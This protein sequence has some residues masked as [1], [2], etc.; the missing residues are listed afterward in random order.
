MTGAFNVG[1]GTTTGVG[2]GTGT[3]VWCG[4]IDGRFL[5]RRRGTAAATAA[6]A[7]LRQE[8][9]LDD[10]V[11]E[12]RRD[13]RAGREVGQHEKQKARVENDGH[14][15][16]AAQLP[17]ARR[18]VRRLSPQPQAG[19][20]TC[21]RSSSQDRRGWEGVRRIHK[22]GHHGD[23]Q[24]HDGAITHSILT[25]HSTRFVPETAVQQLRHD[26][27]AANVAIRRRTVSELGRCS[28]DRGRSSHDGHAEAVLRSEVAWASAHR[29]HT[30][31]AWVF[32]NCSSF[33]PSWS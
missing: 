14:E 7:G 33:S 20:G 2:T 4:G 15:G 1:G 23:Q 17:A 26:K 11:L 30:C 8:H 29:S 16:R 9:H 6:G 18:T 27:M 21:A 32:L 12:V 3:G 25:R 13:F 31:W 10:F 28:R 19:R 5:R 22:L 24:R